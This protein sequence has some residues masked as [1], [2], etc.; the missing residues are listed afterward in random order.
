M[1]TSFFREQQVAKIP[2]NASLFAFA[3]ILVKTSAVNINAKRP[4]L[5]LK[6][7]RR[8]NPIWLKCAVSQAL[9]HQG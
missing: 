9:C 8:G 5:N 2:P 7:N 6:G 1:P 4:N 3:C